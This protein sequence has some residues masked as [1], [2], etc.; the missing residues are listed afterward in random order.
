MVSR[1][2]WRYVCRAG[3]FR[4]R[5]RRIVHM[6]HGHTAQGS[7]IRLSGGWW[8]TVEKDDGGSC[9]A[10]WQRPAW[11]A[12]SVVGAIEAAPLPQRHVDRQSTP[13]CH[14]H[15][16]STSSTCMVQGSNHQ[17]LQVSLSR[18]PSTRPNSPQHALLGARDRAP[19]ISVPQSR[20]S[21]A[22][23]HFC[24]AVSGPK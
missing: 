7:T 16:E 8:C 18:F 15:D 19:D 22:F 24:G 1:K 17:I 10:G 9:V 3:N 12:L 21:V 13:S 14:L 5:L 4:L 6:R 20:V 2:V 23:P 11:Q